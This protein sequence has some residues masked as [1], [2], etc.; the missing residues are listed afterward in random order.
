MDPD[1][2]PDPTPFFSD[3]KDGKQCFCFTF[4]LITYST[5]RHIIVCLIKFKFLLKNFL[6]KHYFIP[7]NTLMRKGKDPDPY[8]LLMDPDPGGPKKHTDPADP[9]PQQ[10]FEG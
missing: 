7:L 9:D 10:W 6:Y 3:F 8:L 1:P 2:N 5:C 4:F